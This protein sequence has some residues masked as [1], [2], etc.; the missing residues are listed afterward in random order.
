MIAINF[1]FFVELGLFLLFMWVTQRIILKPILSVMDRRDDQVTA[2][3]AAA[4]QQAAESES[5]EGRYADEIAGVRRAASTEIETARR[6]GMMAR[7][8]AI[9]ERKAEADQAVRKVEE[10]ALEAM[11]IERKR[12]DS[13]VPGLSERMAK[14]LQLGGES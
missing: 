13:L 11:N 5:L 8:A 12:F 10:A 1:T 4:E 7:A 2:D 9:R 6:D 14:Q 3:E